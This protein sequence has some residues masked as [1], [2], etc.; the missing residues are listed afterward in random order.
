MACVQPAFRRG[1]NRA[2]KKVVTKPLDKSQEMWHTTVVVTKY[3]KTTSTT[4]LPEKVEEDDNNAARCQ[5]SGV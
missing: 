2:H 5:R 4:D 1:E 3:V